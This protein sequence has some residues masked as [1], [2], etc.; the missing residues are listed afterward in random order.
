M[1]KKELVLKTDDFLFLD[2]MLLGLGYHKMTRSDQKKSFQRLGLISPRELTGREVTYFYNNHGYTVIL[3]TTFLQKEKR[4]RDLGEDSGWNLIKEGDK[5][6]YFAKPF[7]RKKG[8]IIKFLRYAWISKWKVD[9]RPLCPSCNAYMN[10]S[11]KKGSRQYFWMCFNYEKHSDLRPFFLSW[12]YLL[13][14]KASSF[15]KIRRSYTARYKKKNK[16]LGVKRTPAPLLRKSWKIS[17]PDN[18]A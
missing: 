7:Q 16:K 2:R 14:K 4:W 17:N 1:D 3:H 6:L 10:I 12:D 18:L 13:P 11:R 8:F 15:L 5:V 9:N